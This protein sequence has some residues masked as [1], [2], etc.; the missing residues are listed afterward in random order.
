MKRLPIFLALPLALALAL[1]FRPDPRGPEAA[2]APTPDAALAAPAFRAAA[3]E[4]PAATTNPPAKGQ[5]RPSADELVE[6]RIA[7]GCG[8]CL[9]AKARETETPVAIA[10]LELAVGQFR[11]CLRHEA[12]VPAA[13]DL[14]ADARGRLEQARE[15]LARAGHPDPTAETTAKTPKGE[16]GE[17]PRTSELL[18]APEAS[19]PAEKP[20]PAVRTPT[21]K[22][23]A[24]PLMVGPDGVIYRRSGR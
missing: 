6:A 1:V 19:P 13:A 22:R 3:H 4:T 20:A 11:A 12:E 14:F 21:G 7:L 8:K 10:L 5:P 23:P 15:L 18:P 24:E 16:D 9:L 17:A 2:G